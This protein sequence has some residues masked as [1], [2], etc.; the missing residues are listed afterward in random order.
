MANILIINTNRSL[1]SSANTSNDVAKW[2]NQV[3]N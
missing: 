3:R 1:G 2:K